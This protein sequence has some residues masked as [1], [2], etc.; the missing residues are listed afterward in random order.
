[1]LLEQKAILDNASVGILFTKA[2]VMLSCNARMA[3]M[4][5]YAP[6]EMEGQPSLLFQSQ[7]HYDFGKDGPSLSA[8]QPFE[9]DA[10]E[11]RRKDGSLFWCRVRARGR[12]QAPRRRHHLDSRRRDALAA[13][14]D[15]GRGHHDQ[16]LDE[17]PVHQEPRHHAL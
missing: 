6:G 8:G 11:F 16:R 3:E 15:G 4:F 5:G 13:D 17:H 7:Q 10:Y 14:A 1:M 2:Q 9:K 12:R